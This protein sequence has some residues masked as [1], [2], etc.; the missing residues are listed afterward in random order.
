MIGDDPRFRMI[1]ASQ[2]AYAP[3]PGGMIKQQ[4]EYIEKHHGPPAKFIY[5]IASAPYLKGRHLVWW[6]GC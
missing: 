3:P 6:P 1:L 5:A 2:V 4:L